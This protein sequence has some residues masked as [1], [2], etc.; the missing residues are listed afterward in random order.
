MDLLTE[1]LHER[2][3]QAMPEKTLTGP[4][5]MAMLGSDAASQHGDMEQL[6]SHLAPAFHSVVLAA[7]S[8]YTE[9]LRELNVQV[10]FDMP[11]EEERRVCHDLLLQ[12]MPL[13]L[14]QT[15]THEHYL[16]H[17]GT[18]PIESQAYKPARI[19]T[20]GEVR[21]LVFDGIG[22]RI[23]GAAGLTP[24]VGTSK[25]S[26]TSLC[27]NSVLF[28][29]SETVSV[30]VEKA[31]AR[32]ISW[33]LIFTGGFLSTLGPLPFPLKELQLILG[34]GQ[35]PEG[36]VR[37]ILDT[38]FLRLHR[39]RRG[40]QRSQTEDHDYLPV[41][42]AAILSW[43]PTRELL[44]RSF[45]GKFT[46][47][48]S[49]AQQA[50]GELLHSYKEPTRRFVDGTDR[51]RLSESGGE[52]EALKPDGKPPRSLE[53]ELPSFQLFKQLC[54][55]MDVQDDRSFSALPGAREY[56]DYVRIAHT[57]PC[58]VD[59]DEHYFL[60]DVAQRI[61]V[62]ASTIHRW[63][64]EGAV[65]NTIRYRTGKQRASYPVFST[66][67]VRKLWLRAPS[68]KAFAEIL[69]QT[70]QAHIYKID[71]LRKSFP[72]LPLQE[73]RALVLRFRGGLPGENS[74]GSPSPTARRK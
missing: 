66:T 67:E 37:E 38:T 43:E 71:T 34:S 69:G 55:I 20:P 4:I 58:I 61:G 30:D 19:V 16:H 13:L 36:T 9:F 50:V 47:A 26:S 56:S 49:V 63:I 44:N 14:H 53:G 17:V 73:L 74:S 25:V 7:W 52:V 31:V 10:P 70:E 2:I 59:G 23:F 33:R 68:R 65:P 28:Q 15:P 6:A 29:P 8:S 45:N 54:G 60:P 11:L 51:G 3:G 12:G 39:N 48:L 32:W 22:G 5:G 21:H 42:V 18:T 41:V 24:T 1:L 72:G 46:L 40:G 27:G 57:E 62:R 35:L 64:R